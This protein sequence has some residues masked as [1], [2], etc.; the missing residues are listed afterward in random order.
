MKTIKLTIDTGALELGPVP[1][2]TKVTLECGYLHG[3]ESRVPL[4]EAFKI[5]DTDA[6]NRAA[7]E[8][9]AEHVVARWSVSPTLDRSAVEAF[10]L[11]LYDEE[12]AAIVE[13]FQRIGDASKFDRPRLID[14]EELGEA[15]R[16]G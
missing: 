2:G 12:P 16:P 8:R 5:V 7:I 6:R 11:A 3:K 15:V 10:L 1:A 14:V 9:I 13:I 4:A